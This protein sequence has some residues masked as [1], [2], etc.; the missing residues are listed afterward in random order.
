V[1][2]SPS[3]LLQF[4]GPDGISLVPLF[5]LPQGFPPLGGEGVRQDQYCDEIAALLCEEGKLMDA[6]DS[7]AAMAIE[8]YLREN[9]LHIGP[10]SESPSPVRSV[11][12][13]AED[14]AWADAAAS[15]KPSAPPS[16]AGAEGELPPLPDDLEDEDFD[17]AEKECI[18]LIRDGVLQVLAM[19]ERQF[20]DF[21]AR[22]ALKPSQPSGGTVKAN[23]IIR[24]VEGQVLIECR[25]CGECSP[26]PSPDELSAW[27][28]APSAPDGGSGR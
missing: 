18:G 12:Q 1:Q 19:R 23:N 6:N 14:K 15:L 26:L 4:R 24:K 27:F 11:E 22:A 9:N 25:A 7:W 17:F 16:V 3:D 20:R 21:I 8:T 13:A 5:I 28:V 2:K 10:V